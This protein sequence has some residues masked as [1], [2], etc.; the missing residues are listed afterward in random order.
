MVARAWRSAMRNLAELPNCRMR[1]NPSAGLIGYRRQT[2][3]FRSAISIA[4]RS[5]RPILLLIQG[6]CRDRT[7]Q[8]GPSRNLSTNWTRTINPKTVNEFRFAFSGID[9]SFGLTPETAA[10]PQ[11]NGATCSSLGCCLALELE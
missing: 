7:Q 10:N 4:H 1:A 9:S 2:I 11:A 3:R 8:G 5:L 6:S